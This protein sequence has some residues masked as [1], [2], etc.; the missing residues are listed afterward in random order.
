MLWGWFSAKGTGRLPHFEGPVYRKV[1]NENRLSS[2]SLKIGCGWVFLHDSNP[3]HTAKPTKEWRKKTHI[4]VM[5]WPT[6]SRD[7]NPSDN[8]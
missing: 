4:K 3:K 2:A 5:Q 7:L 1:L 6:Q 8:L